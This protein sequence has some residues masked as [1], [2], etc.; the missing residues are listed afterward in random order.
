[1][2]QELLENAPIACS[3]DAGAFKA[4][5]AWIAELNRSALR[6]QRRDD[7]RLELTYNTAARDDVFELVRR[8]EACC[9]FLTFQILEK[10]DLVQMI[11]V[12]PERARDAADLV[13]APFL[14]QPAPNLSCSCCNPS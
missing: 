13:F 14:S 12:A 3:L 6:G 4:R 9:A 2:T 1:M 5:L 7:L 8:E 11:I 10:S